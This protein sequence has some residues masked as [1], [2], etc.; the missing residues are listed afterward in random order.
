MDIHQFQPV[1]GSG[2]SRAVAPSGP[3]GCP[4]LRRWLVRPNYKSK[5][6]AR[7]AKSRSFC[8]VGLALA[9]R[10]PPDPPH[11]RWNPFAWGR[12]ALLPTLRAAAGGTPRNP[13]ITKKMVV[14]MTTYYLEAIDAHLRAR[15][16]RQRVWRSSEIAFLDT[17][18]SR[19][20]GSTA[21]SHHGWRV[22]FVFAT[23]PDT[24]LAPLP[25]SLHGSGVRIQNWP[26]MANSQIFARQYRKW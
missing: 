5:T 20:S 26:G 16:T 3:R 18:F 21:T 13:P 14:I 22:R 7:S 4:S 12:G 9:L 15:T 23:T 19:T 2:E 8:G 24:V 11:I 6:M 17:N 1:A 25:R 10:G